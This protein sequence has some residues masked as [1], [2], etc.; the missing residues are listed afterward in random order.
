MYI[1]VGGRS[2][3]ERRKKTRAKARRRTRLGKAA[4]IVVFTVLL[5]LLIPAFPDLTRPLADN[6]FTVSGRHQPPPPPPKAEYAVVY[7]SGAVASPGV[8]KVPAGTTVADVIRLAGGLAF[9]ADTAKL[10][11]TR[12][13]ADEMHIHINQAPA[14]Q[15]KK[16]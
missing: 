13:V 5:T 3:S 15:T 4:A 16:K 1:P 14:P 7:V 6:I 10:D 11:L 2:R 12:P 8:V 9:G